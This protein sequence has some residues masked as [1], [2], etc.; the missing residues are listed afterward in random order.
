M[1]KLFFVYLPTECKHEKKDVFFLY[2][3]GIRNGGDG[4]LFHE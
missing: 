3:S 4:Y 1:A 2:E